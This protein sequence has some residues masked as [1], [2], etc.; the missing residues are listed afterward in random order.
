MIDKTMPLA[1]NETILEALRTIRDPKDS[2]DVVSLGLIN[3]LSVKDGHVTFAL[4]VDPGE[5]NAR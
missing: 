1:T 2:R 3:G 5:G 4:D